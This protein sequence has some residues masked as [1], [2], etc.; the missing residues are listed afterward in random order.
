ME[1]TRKEVD[2]TEWPELFADKIV[3]DNWGGP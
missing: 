2:G 1:E 3:E